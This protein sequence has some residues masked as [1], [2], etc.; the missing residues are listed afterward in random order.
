M[1]GPRAGALSQ[2][3]IATIDT[4][5]M[6]LDDNHLDIEG[7]IFFDANL[8]VVEAVGDMTDLLDLPKIQGKDGSAHSRLK[9]YKLMELRCKKYG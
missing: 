3:S 5:V 4:H 2:G 6:L 1:I 7:A 9:K 8:V